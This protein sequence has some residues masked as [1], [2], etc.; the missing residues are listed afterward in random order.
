VERAHMSLAD[1]IA[2]P[3]TIL[4]VGVFKA[5]IGLV[6]VMAGIIGTNYI[7]DI[8]GTI[9]RLAV[10]LGDMDQRVDALERES[11][12][13]SAMYEEDRAAYQRQRDEWEKRQMERA[14]AK[15]AEIAA[16]EE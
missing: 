7:G 12:I 16:G 11:A 8:K 10:Q 3:V 1:I 6:V 9:E 4:V 14:K 2:H 13:R 15:A 5:L